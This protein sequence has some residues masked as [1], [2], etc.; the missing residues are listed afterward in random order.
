MGF[1]DLKFNLSQVTQAA[2]SRQRLLDISSIDPAYGYKAWHGISEVK[3]L[4]TVTT[5]KKVENIGITSIPYSQ[6]T[7]FVEINKGITIVIDDFVEINSLKQLEQIEFDP[8][9]ELFVCVQRASSKYLVSTLHNLLPVLLFE[10]DV[11]FFEL[12]NRLNPNNLVWEHSSATYNSFTMRYGSSC[13][14]VNSDNDSSTFEL[15]QLSLN[16]SIKGTRII[17][18]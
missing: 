6:W 8:S 4:I 12:L 14:S 11:F 13:V 3:L 15:M 1:P 18:I 17:K 16:A 5:D 7:E 9:I 10:G 2:K